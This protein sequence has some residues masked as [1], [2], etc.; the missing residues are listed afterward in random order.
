MNEI[1]KAYLRKFVLVFFYDILVFS[2][3]WEDHLYH[4]ELVLK[5]LQQQQL[6][7]RLSKCSFGV[8]EIDY[9]GHTLSGTG[10]AMENDKLEA[11][12][13]WPIPTTVKQL[14]GFLGFS[15]YYRRFVKG[16]ATIAAPL[17]DLLKKD[18]FQCS[19]NAS[20]AFDKLKDALTS[21]PVLAIP[22]FSEPFVLETN[23]SGSKLELFLAN[24]NIQLLTFQ[25]NF[26]LE[27][28]NNLCISENF[29][30]SQRH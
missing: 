10:V 13:K 18:S 19:P 17:T 6:F 22:N 30:S 5:T 29:M 4:L 15:G 14:R 24:L 2:A 11:V 1:F 12:K 21:A 27:C 16:Y 8:R 3:T 25:R 20:L 26:L 9:L 23:A 7:A 28:R